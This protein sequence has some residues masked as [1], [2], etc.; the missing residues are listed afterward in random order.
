MGHDREQGPDVPSG[1][2]GEEAIL[3][4]PDES[5]FPAVREETPEL[6]VAGLPIEKPARSPISAMRP[7]HMASGLLVGVF[8]VLGATMDPWFLPDLTPIFGPERGADVP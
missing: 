7:I 4:W 2:P 8:K 1:T 6:L 5:R 3:A